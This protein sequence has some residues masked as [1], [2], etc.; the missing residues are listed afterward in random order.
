M[1]LTPHVLIR[2]TPEDRKTA[3][4][5][6]PTWAKKRV[7]SRHTAGNPT[8]HLADVKKKTRGAIILWGGK[9]S[10]GLQV[11]KRKRWMINTIQAPSNT[12]PVLPETQSKGGG[13]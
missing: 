6:T 7:N 11:G 4:Y 10:P 5:E 3:C 12:V 8:M 9:K 2:I 13:Y 1:P